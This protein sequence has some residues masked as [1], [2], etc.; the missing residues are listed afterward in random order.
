M[1]QLLPQNYRAI[2]AKSWYLIAGIVLE[3]AIFIV[4]T[5]LA[6]H[7]FNQYSKTQVFRTRELKALATWEH[8]ILKFPNYPEVYYNSAL[9]EA[10]VGDKEKALLNLAASLKINPNYEP[11]IA[12]QKQLSK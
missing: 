1:K 11:S 8:L 2:T 7:L 5:V 10:R 4:L 12:L 9:Y 6:L 3:A